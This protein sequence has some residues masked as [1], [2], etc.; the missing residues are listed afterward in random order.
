MIIDEERRLV[1]RTRTALGFPSLEAA[2]ADYE[3]MLESYEHIDRPE[4]AL[5]ID[6]R[7]APPRNDPAFEKMVRAYHDRLYSG[8]RRLA[9]LV[10]TQAGKLQVTRLFQRSSFAMRVFHDD[11]AGALEYLSSPGEAE[12]AQEASLRTRTGTGTSQIRRAMRK[13]P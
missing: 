3:A 11:E 4:Y 8:F 12:P 10:K 1:R 5:L 13:A 7:A 6:V 9:T 2:Q